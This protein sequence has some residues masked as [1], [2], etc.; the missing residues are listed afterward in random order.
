MKEVFHENEKDSRNVE[1]RSRFASSKEKVE[2]IKK[3][4]ELKEVQKVT[5]LLVR[6]RVSNKS[7]ITDI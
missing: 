6:K 4:K 1:E 7:R 3:I 2:I 5:S